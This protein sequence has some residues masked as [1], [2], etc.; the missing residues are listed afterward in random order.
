MKNI[1]NLSLQE[2]LGQILFI[3]FNPTILAEEFYDKPEIVFIYG[4]ELMKGMQEE[5]IFATAKHFPR[6]GD[7]EI[8]PLFCLPLLPFDKEKL[9]NVEVKPFKEAIKN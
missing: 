1:Q 9:N 3:S 5:G 7:V 2:K 4:I 8:A 6:H